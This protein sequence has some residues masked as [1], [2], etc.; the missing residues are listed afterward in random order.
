MEAVV[1]LVAGVVS[2]LA[3]RGVDH[4]LS[5]WVAY[6]TIALEKSASKRAREEYKLAMEQ[7]VTD[8]ASKYDD[9]KKWKDS[10]PK[11]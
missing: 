10:L 1:N 5:K 3:A 9:W 6:F 11:L 7:M 2:Y 4:V 8:L